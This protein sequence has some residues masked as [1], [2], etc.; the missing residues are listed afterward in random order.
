MRKKLFF[1]A[2]AATALISWA[3]KDPVL[4]KIN[5]D[6]VKLSEFE[7]LY[8]KNNQQQIEKESLEQYLERFKIYKLKVADAKAAGIDTT[9]SFR[10]EFQKYRNDLSQPYMTDSATLLRF[11]QEAYDRKLREV[12]TMHIMLPLTPD[13]SSIAKADSL[14][15][16]ILNGEDMGDLAVKYSIDRSAK[17]NRGNL[18]YIVSGRFPYAFE[19]VAYTLPIGEVSKPFATDFGIHI[20]KTLAERPSRGEVLV[21]HILKLYPR[22]ATLTDSIKATMHAQIDSIYKEVL[23]G[24]DFE[25]LARKHSDD[26]SA[27]NGGRLNWF[28]S[29]M[30]VPQFEATAFEL[31]NGEVSK[32]IETMFGWHIIKKLDSRGVKPFDECKTGILETIA[33]DERNTEARNAKISQLKNEYKLKENS[34]FLAM[35][36]NDSKDTFDSTTVEKIKSYNCVAFSFAKKKVM[37]SEIAERLNHKMK[38]ANESAVDYVKGVMENIEKEMLIEHEKDMLPSKHADYANLLNEYY[39]GMLLFEISNRNVWDKANTD[40]E[41]LEKYFQANKSKYTW[42]KPKFKGTVIYTTSDSIENLVKEAIAKMGGDTIFT[43]LRKQF[44]RDVRIEQLLVEKGE[45]AV[46][47]NLVFNGPAAKHKDKRYTN[48]FKYEGRIINQPESAADV[49]GPVT[50]DYQNALEEEWIRQLKEKYLIEVNTKV[51]KQVK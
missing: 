41:G 37:A 42:S 16:C 20:V 8:H 18:G 38:K 50:S 4:M 9:K 28:G 15:N 10:S 5:G 25:E 34:K 23:K 31:A 48:Y 3:A 46:V 19:Y 44:K 13:G 29:G 2:L 43:A 36:E 1:G 45:N 17:R 30:M 7:Y 12:E 32:P 24:A 26:G 21:E 6:K 47:D 14:R 33:A 35:V 11:A 40:K 27:R 39:N 22:G 49:R 51:L